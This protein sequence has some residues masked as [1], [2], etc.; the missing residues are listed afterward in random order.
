LSSVLTA[1]GPQVI[2]GNAEGRLKRFSDRD[3][4]AAGCPRAAITS[5]IDAA[6]DVDGCRPERPVG[7]RAAEVAPKRTSGTSETIK[8]RNTNTLRYVGGRFPR[9]CIK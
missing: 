5:D 7:S 8:P 3:F 6:V 9:F 1:T 2:Y 4:A